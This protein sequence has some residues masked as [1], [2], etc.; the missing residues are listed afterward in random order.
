MQ[1]QNSDIMFDELYAIGPGSDYGNAIWHDFD[2]VNNSKLFPY[3]IGTNNVFLKLLH[4]IHFSFALNKNFD[5][6]FQSVWKRLY[7][8]ENV[9]FDDNKHYLV[10]FPDVSACR[11]D[12]KYLSYLQK[13]DNICLVLYIINTME[14]KTRLVL[15]RIRFFDVVFSFN[16]HDAQK[17]GFTFWEA[18][19][20]KQDALENNDIKSDFFFAGTAT[21]NRIKLL[22]QIKE[23]CDQ[24]GLV[25]DFHLNGVQKKDIAD[26]GIAYN[27]PISY[28]EVLQ[29]TLST[30]CIV[31]IL[32]IRGHCGYTMRTAEAV[33]YNKKLVTNNEDIKESI[34]YDP[35]KINYF[36]TIDD[37]DLESLAK[38]EPIDY[39]YQ[40]EFSPLNL[41][42]SNEIRQWIDA[43]GK[44]E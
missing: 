11:V 13:K 4:H 44:D 16:E 35:Q 28:S 20:S 2:I 34:F 42:K 29:R 21:E 3:V 25:C 12:T 32:A 19:Y 23:L 33:C 41:L 17:Y 9:E 36:E 38:K 5:L 15:D 10:L 14:R 18:V 6:P 26:D 43:H 1:T 7:S 39:M 31:E 8:L 30:R 22:R 27:K 40:N 24:K 37:I